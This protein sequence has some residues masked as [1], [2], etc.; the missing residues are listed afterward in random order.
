[1]QPRRFYVNAKK[2][3][4]FKIL[5]ST[6]PLPKKFPTFI[7]NDSRETQ[8]KLS[9]SNYND[10]MFMQIYSGRVDITPRQIDQLPCQL[11]RTKSIQ[12][13][14]FS[15]YFILSKFY[16]QLKSTLRSYKLVVVPNYKQG[17]LFCSAS[18]LIENKVPAKGRLFVCEQC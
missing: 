17:Y 13:E 14:S 6:C 15:N 1:M 8:R 2:R 9:I 7:R 11:K 12:R 10:T 5:L 16:S 4:L 3:F 18:K